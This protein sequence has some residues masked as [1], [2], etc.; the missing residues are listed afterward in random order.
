[1]QVAYK[2]KLEGSTGRPIW[3][4]KPEFTKYLSIEN[5]ESTEGWVEE[6]VGTT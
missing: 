4:I 1:M 3:I 6:E 2:D 5:F